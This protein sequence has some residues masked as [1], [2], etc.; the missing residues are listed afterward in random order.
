MPRLTAGAGAGLVTLR[1]QRS[2][3][4]RYLIGFVGCLAILAALQSWNYPFTHR[5]GDRFADGL[6]ARMTFRVVNAFET[7]RASRDRERE[8]PLIFRNDPTEL[9]RLPER[10]KAALGVIA[11]AKQLGDVS[12]EVQRAFGLLPHSE[13][14]VAEKPGGDPAQDAE[15][16]FRQLKQ[17]ITPLDGVRSETHISTIIDELVRLIEPLYKKGLVN[18]KVLERTEI[19]LDSQL[20]IVD[21]QAQ[22]P[23][24]N[25]LADEQLWI[26]VRITDVAMSDLLNDAGYLSQ[27]W[28]DY[29]TLETIR[30]PLQAWLRNQSRPTLEYDQSA[31]QQ[32]RRWAGRQVEP[33]YDVINEGDVF[34]PPDGVIDQNLLR[35]LEAEYQASLEMFPWE[36]R[37]ARIGIVFLMILMFLGA[38][39]LVPGA[40][41]TVCD[42]QLAP[43]GLVPDRGGGGGAAGALDLL[44]PR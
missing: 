4:L 28:S 32:A 26:S 6:A 15:F 36:A 2:R 37:L 27:R 44:R 11:E 35:V 18:P 13:I 42:C 14:V 9:R 7:S 25:P 20:A 3:L 22:L 31:T 19:G 21:R 43:S 39:C 16:R 8:V 5:I 24:D 10:L 12:E 29:P 40:L 17:A 33:V 34:L 23:D 30:Q 41:R 38:D 1:Q